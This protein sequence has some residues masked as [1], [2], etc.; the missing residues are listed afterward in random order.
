[1]VPTTVAVPGRPKQRFTLLPPVDREDP[2]AAVE[3]GKA[4]EVSSLILVLGQTER[5]LGG[6]QRSLCLAGCW[7]RLASICIGRKTLCTTCVFLPPAAC[8]CAL[9]TQDSEVALMY[10]KKLLLIL[11][12]IQYTRKPAFDPIGEHRAAKKGV[13][14]LHSIRSC[15]PSVSYHADITFLWITF[16]L[17]S[18]FQLCDARFVVSGG[19][20]GA[21]GPEQSGVHRQRR[22][23]GAVGAAPAGHANRDGGGHRFAPRSGRDGRRQNEG[24]GGCPQAR[25]H[26]LGFGG[27]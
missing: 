27:K 24:E 8:V 16:P 3:L 26:R 23:P 11:I 6:S 21:A 15:L 14:R 25:S 13:C 19:D 18:S 5:C 20:S 4:A 1:M 2:L 10:R 17:R 12:H 9:P 22:P 7:H